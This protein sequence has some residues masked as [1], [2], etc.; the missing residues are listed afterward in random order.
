MCWYG[1]VVV[2]LFCNICGGKPYFLVQLYGGGRFWG[3]HFSVEVE[4]YTKSTT[5]YKFLL[6]LS[7]DFLWCVVVL[8]G[9]TLFRCRI[10]SLLTCGFGG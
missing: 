2:Q 9:V 5:K 8:M 6:V 10:V 7:S 4:P 3:F 1:G